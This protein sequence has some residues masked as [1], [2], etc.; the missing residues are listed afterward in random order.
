MSFSV[1][2]SAPER[3]LSSGEPRTFQ[4]NVGVADPRAQNR[5]EFLM[6]LD[7]TLDYDTIASLTYEQYGGFSCRFCF[8][9]LVA[10]GSN[11]SGTREFLCR[12]CGRKM[13]LYN[14]FELSTFRYRKLLSAFLSYVH[15]AS[16]DGSASLFG[17]GKDLFNE[18]RMSLPHIAYSR[19]GGPD[20]VEYCG[21]RYALVT[22]D[23]MYKGHRGLMLGVSGGLKF[24]NI[25]NE[26]TGDGMDQF[27]TTL[28]D[29]IGEEKIIFLMD[30]KMSVARKILDR[31][32]EKAIIILQSHRIWGDVFVY[33]HRGEWYTL[34]LRTDAFSSASVKRNESLLLPPGMIELF[35][36][37]KGVTHRNPIRK[38][39]DQEIFKMASNCIDQ[40]RFVDWN[41]KGRIDMVMAA[42]VRDLAASLK[43]LR[44]RRA[45][46]TTLESDIDLTISRIEEAYRRRINRSVKRKIVNAWRSFPMHDRVNRLSIVLLGEPLAN[47]PSKKVAERTVRISSP[48]RLVYRG[49][50]NGSTQEGTWIIGLLAQIF[51]GKEITTNACEG[52]FGNMG[53]LIRS[54]RSILL[55]R[56]LTKNMLASNDIEETAEWFNSAY[57]MSDMGRRGKRGHR[58]KI[59]V[60]RSYKITYSD[61]NTV[62]TERVID[63][64]ER[65]RKY[66]TA[67]CHLRNEI[68]TFKRSRIKSIVQV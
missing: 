44:R 18:L 24:G 65:R 32:K 64:V 54:G 42:K 9:P 4:W 40:I 36:G 47:R 26:D 19:T 34:H 35:S 12:K 45:D 3:N 49:P 52:T 57:P 61:Y 33:F 48:A 53:T 2:Y 8:S 17:L 6:R 16:S 15:S 46:S 39:S 25:G 5:T 58:T 30:M 66:I 22:I 27:F 59:I 41:A 14:T 23:M 28:N 62:K 13:S 37:L 56:A 43:E 55:E 11:G 50:E 20:I 51:K 7:P 63:V 67:F 38:L 29:L 68:R 10:D 31:W 1:D 21:E 60:G